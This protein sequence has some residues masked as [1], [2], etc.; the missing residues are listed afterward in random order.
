MVSR[1]RFQTS[2]E[3]GAY[4]LLTNS[5]C[6]L[7]EISSDSYFVS[8]F[9]NAIEKENFPIIN[10]SIAG[11]NIVGRLAV[12]NKHGLILPLTANQ[13]EISRIR[14]QLPESIEIAQ[15]DEKL[16][17]LGNVISCNDKIAL[18]HP[19]IEQETIDIIQDVL[20]VEPV[21]PSLIG[22]ES[23]VGSYSIFTNKGGVVSPN[24]TK[25]Q[26]DE[27]SNFLGISIS[28]A[29]VNKGSNLVG[30]GICVNDDILICGWETT[31]FE[32]GTLT[33]VFKITETSTQNDGMFGVDESLNDLLI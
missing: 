17:A 11:T 15:I 26:I 2:S 25:E 33:R 9:T 12:G 6:I 3:V 31:A 32:I 30:A 10:S 23:L 21:I 20:Q 19:E 13:L 16:S 27:L 28:S 24:C 1:C 7:P 29:T 4:A 14:E 8:Q 5:Y 18:V 22:T